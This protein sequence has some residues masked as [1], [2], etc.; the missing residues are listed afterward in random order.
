[1]ALSTNICASGGA[2]GVDDAGGPAVTP[3]IN[4]AMPHPG[5]LVD[6]FLGGKNNFRSGPCRGRSTPTEGSLASWKA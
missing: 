6:Y 1:V 4:T 5:P 2:T 3:E